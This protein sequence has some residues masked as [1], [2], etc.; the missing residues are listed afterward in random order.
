[1]HHDPLQNQAEEQTAENE[2]SAL[3][4]GQLE[5]FGHQVTRLKGSGRESLP[6]LEGFCQN[7]APESAAVHEVETDKD[8]IKR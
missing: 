3:N 1:M 8:S 6:G 4:P 5:E 2:E 7:P